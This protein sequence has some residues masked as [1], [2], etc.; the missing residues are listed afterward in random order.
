MKKLLITFGALIILTS[1]GYSSEDECLL[2]EMQQCNSG[3]CELEAKYYCYDKF[4]GDSWYNT[5]FDWI[6]TV[7]WWAVMV[8][9]VLFWCALIYGALVGESEDKRLSRWWLLGMAALAL[10]I[11]L[12]V[13]S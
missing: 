7:G 6:L 9:G 3:A 12:T 13:F 1:C 10:V 4:S 2:K 5:L 11:G 8:I